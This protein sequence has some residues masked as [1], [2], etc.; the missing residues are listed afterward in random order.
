M[1]LTV[2]TSHDDGY[3]DELKNYLTVSISFNLY[4]FKSQNNVFE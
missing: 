2:I 1:K 4:L 3:G